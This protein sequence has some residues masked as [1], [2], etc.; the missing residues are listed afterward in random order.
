MDSTETQFVGFPKMARLHREIVI[1]EKLDG[2]NAQVYLTFDDP[3]KGT[4]VVAV[5]LTEVGPMSIYAGSRN[6]WITPEDDNFGFAR[7]VADNAVQLAELGPGRHFG[8]WWGKGIQRGYGLNEKRFSLFNVTRW[9]TPPVCCHV[10][11]V[12]YT[13]PFD[14]DEVENAAA[15]LRREGSAAAPG[16]DK[17]EGI[18]VFHTAANVAFK[19]TLENDDV[20]KSKGQK[21]EPFNG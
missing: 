16:F 6:R 20:P 3:P 8:E 2:T 14:L 1:T 13:G 11:P 4:P 7:W 12:L 5:V 9:S 18:V 19:Q 21:T 10:V 17:P 15:H